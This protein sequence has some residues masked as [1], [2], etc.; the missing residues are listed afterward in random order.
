LEVEIKMAEEIQTREKP[1]MIE[2]KS[3]NELV[4]RVIGQYICTIVRSDGKIIE[5]TYELVDGRYRYACSNQIPQGHPRH[6][7]LNSKL[8]E[9]GK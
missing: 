5:N 6:S 4:D 3:G 1:R 7:G 9:A 8:D 2:G